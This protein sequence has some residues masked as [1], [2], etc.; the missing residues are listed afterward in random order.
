LRSSSRG[1]S[2]AVAKRPDSFALRLLIVN[3]DDF[4]LARGVNEG[5]IE[6][7]TG[8]I[9]TSTSLMV[10]APAA[11]EAA[12]LARS[13][14]GLSV[15]LHFAQDGTADLDDPV[16]AARS[17]HAQLERFRELIGRNPTHVDS[18]HHVHTEN[19]R[20]GIF[21]ALVEPLAAPLRGDGRVAY[22]GG[23]WPEREP[24]ITNL[25]YIGR[26]FLRHLVDTEVGHGFTELGCHPGR[27]TDDLHSSYA[28]EREVE[29]Q[30]LTEEG[31]GA[32]LEG[33]GVKLVSY[34]AWRPGSRPSTPSG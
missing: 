24:G 32:E 1:S 11:S 5:V 17:F 8:G 25:D 29:L 9:L 7:H 27:V 21:G 16:Q 34:D 31:L 19:D 20:I 26:P 13:H 14:P 3:A 22:V 23:F 33:A 28:R 18:H 4:G 12:A 15:G 6:A 30:T 2:R 10:F